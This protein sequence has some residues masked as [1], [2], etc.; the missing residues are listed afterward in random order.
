M[1]VTE[2][3]TQ[4]ERVAVEDMGVYLK[5]IQMDYQC[6]SDDQLATLISEQ[7]NVDCRES[8]IQGYENLYRIKELED[9]EKLSRMAQ[10]GNV[11]HLIE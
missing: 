11:E 3:I 1:S 5:L 4:R 8:D 2:H 9:H 6:D 10:N 7:F